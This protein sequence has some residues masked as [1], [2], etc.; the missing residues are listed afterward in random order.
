MFCHLPFVFHDLIDFKPLTLFFTDVF[1]CLFLFFKQ[2]TNV[3]VYIHSAF[4]VFESV[5][6]I[7]IDLPESPGKHFK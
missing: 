3:E 4:T 6:E 1:V 2:E 5:L 7:N